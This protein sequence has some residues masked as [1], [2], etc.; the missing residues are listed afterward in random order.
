[1]AVPFCLLLSLCLLAWGDLLMFSKYRNNKFNKQIK[2]E[3]NFILFLCCIYGTIN[4]PL[5]MEKKKTYTINA[6]PSAVALFDERAKRH[7]RSRSGQ[8][9]YEAKNGETQNVGRIFTEREIQALQN[10]VHAITGNGQVMACFNKML[11]ICAGD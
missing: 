7:G 9:E 2:N 8:F 5:N 11:G 6:T 3:I 10:E 1:M 4:L